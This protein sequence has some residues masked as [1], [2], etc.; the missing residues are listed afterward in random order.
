MSWHPARRMA[1][2]LPSPRLQHYPGPQPLVSPALPALVSQHPWGEKWSGP[3][4]KPNQGLDPCPCLPLSRSPSWYPGLLTLP[5]WPRFTSRAHGG[6]FPRSGVPCAA[7]GQGVAAWAQVVGR[8]WRYRL[9]LGTCRWARAP[10]ECWNKKGTGPDLR[11]SVPVPPFGL[12]STGI[13]KSNY[14]FDCVAS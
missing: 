3:R 6:P 8:M 1:T 13:L 4:E 2:G 9:V 10:A 7:S 12:R 11:L 14:I 5:K